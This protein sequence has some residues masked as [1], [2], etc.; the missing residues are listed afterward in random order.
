MIL[1]T[2]FCRGRSWGIKNWN[3]VLSI[4]HLTCGRNEIWTLRIQLTR[5]DSPPPIVPGKGGLQD[6]LHTTGHQENSWRF[7]EGW[8]HCVS[9]TSFPCSHV[10]KFLA[11]FHF[12]LFPLGCWV[13]FTASNTVWNR[14][15]RTRCQNE[16][17]EKCWPSALLPEGNLVTDHLASGVC[18]RSDF[19]HLFSFHVFLLL[20]SGETFYILFAAEAKEGELN[21]RRESFLSSTHSFQTLVKE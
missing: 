13:N 18:H 20:N 3:N 9:I 21:K 16:G 7:N 11:R 8:L 19:Q 6:N 12:V 5:N 14:K 4:I 1:F 2:P 17:L 10:F 15:M